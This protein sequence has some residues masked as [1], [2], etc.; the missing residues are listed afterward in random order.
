VRLTGE[1]KYFRREKEREGKK[2]GAAEFRE[3]KI[4][5]MEE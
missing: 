3:R 4:G 1:R 5:G 2:K